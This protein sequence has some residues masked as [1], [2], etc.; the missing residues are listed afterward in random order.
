M[1]DGPETSA[2]LATLLSVV[3]RE[4]IIEPDIDA[5]IAR[6]AAIGEQTVT[7]EAWRAAVTEA[8]WAGYIHDPVRLQAGA[9]QCHWHL[10]LTPQGVEAVRRLPMKRDV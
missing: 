2:L 8:V 1:S 6:L 3:F 5:G 4:R 9:L 10:E 7:P